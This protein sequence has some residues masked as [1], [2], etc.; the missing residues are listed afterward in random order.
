MS[1]IQDN[2][3]PLSRAVR[4][5]IIDLYSDIGHAYELHSHWAARRLRE[6]QSHILRSPKRSVYLRVNH[7][8]QTATLPCDFETEQFVGYI[9]NG[10]KI[11][12]FQDGRLADTQNITS[13]P[14]EVCNKCAQPTSICNDLQITET[15]NLI[16]INDEVYEQTI[17]KKLYPN[18][19]YYLETTSPYVV[20]VEGNE[21][22]EYS[23]SKEFITNFDLQACGCLATTPENLCTLETYCPD[24]YGCYYAS[25]DDTCGVTRYGGYRIFEETGLIQ[26]DLG[27]T[28]DYVYLEYK[29][30]MAKINGQYM[31]PA[32]AFEA[33]VE[34]VKF[35][36]IEGKSSVSNPDKRWRWDMYMIAKGNL[37]K[38]KGRFSLSSI[39][40]AAMRT[41]KFDIGN[42][43]WYSCYRRNAVLC[44]TA[45]AAT[46][47]TC[48]V[49]PTV[50]PTTSTVV[51]VTRGGDVYGK[52]KFTIGTV[53][54][55]MLAGDTVYI[56]KNGAGV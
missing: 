1:N 11:P 33:I 34:G 30:F 4:A 20:T 48:P 25:C 37:R 12:L 15:V 46:E 22:V 7:N 21:T 28:L 42:D 53:G 41:P 17:V 23:T 47:A 54:A 6:L 13:E 45:T 14:V 8:T 51:Y 35:S 43:N 32:I 16:T 29:G 31:I 9:T 36:S 49:E 38:M 3:I 52:T 44:D 19:D 26:L 40:Q 55:Q 50:I 27:Y 2:L 56:L 18:G 39:M 10:K 5:S 24:I